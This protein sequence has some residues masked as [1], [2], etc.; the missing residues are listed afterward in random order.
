MKKLQ[1]AVVDAL[2][3]INVEAR[4]DPTAPGVWCPDPAA[5]GQLAKVGAVGVRVK[6]GIT[7]HGLALNVEPDLSFFKLIVPCGLDRPVTSLHRLLGSRAP[8]LEAVKAVLV[9]K[10]ISQ[11]GIPGTDGPEVSR[12]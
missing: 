9:K 12:P 5:N 10:L 4:L 3:A 2:A 7:M 1:L 11:F 6:R 8:S